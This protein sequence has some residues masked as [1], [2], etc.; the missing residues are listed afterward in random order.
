MAEKEKQ[1]EK[2][3]KECE[4]FCQKH[5]L[6]QKGTYS[7]FGEG[8]INAKIMLIG[9]A[10]GLNESLTGHPFCGESGK[11]LDELLN[12]AEIKRE[13]IYIT[14]IVKLRP[15][16]NQNPNTEE[17]KEF[18]PFLDKEIEIIK[19]KA[20]CTLGNFSTAYILEKYGLKSEIQGISKIH[21]Q[22]FEPKTLF[23]TIKI[24]PLYHPA[25]AAYNPNMKEILKKDF[26]ILVKILDI[27]D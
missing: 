5:P 22:I 7:V 13:E 17:I 23:E 21:G 26:Q 15:P 6:Y 11:I 27:K 14:N 3:K 24:I 20:I 16:N 10:P 4:E 1:I 8:S 19:P 9:E 18:A 25:V 12:S 2:L